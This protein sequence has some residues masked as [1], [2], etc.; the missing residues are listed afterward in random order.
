MSD[1]FRDG[2]C[3]VCGWQGAVGTACSSLGAVSF[4][5]C[6]DCLASGAEPFAML[7]YTVAVC[8]GL[9][10]MVAAIRDV[11]VPATLRRTRRTLDELNAEAAAMYAEWDAEPS[12]SDLEAAGQRSL[13]DGEA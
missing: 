5:F 4:A 11:T 9:D 7:A 13:L 8:G 3:S 12:D 10:N 2:Q 1:Y 6:K